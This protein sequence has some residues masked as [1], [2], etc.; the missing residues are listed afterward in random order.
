MGNVVRYKA[1][2][3]RVEPRQGGLEEQRRPLCVERA[4]PLPCA[5]RD[6]ALRTRGKG[7]I[8]GVRHRVQV[9]GLE[10]AAFEAPR[11]GLFGKFPGGEGYRP[12]A[13]LATAEALLLRGGD[14]HSVHDQRCGWV[15]ED[16]IYS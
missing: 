6:V 15:V 3:R 7:R 4:K 12:L 5:R 10:A 9:L 13:V 2:D 16:R 1:N 14:R 8:V 11:R